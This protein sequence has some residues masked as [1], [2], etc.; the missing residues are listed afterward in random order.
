MVLI[1]LV[2][3]SL[4]FS[5]EIALLEQGKRTASVRAAEPTELCMLSKSSFKELV[6]SNPD[7]HRKI[8]QVVQERKERDAKRKADEEAK[9]KADEEAKK[10]AFAAANTPEAVAVTVPNAAGPA[11]GNGYLNIPRGEDSTFPRRTTMNRISRI[12]G[13]GRR[14]HFFT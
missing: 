8:M 9:K 14:S 10:M 12:F 5:G 11:Q 1:F 7:I 3:G 4:I 13:T 2:S 6:D